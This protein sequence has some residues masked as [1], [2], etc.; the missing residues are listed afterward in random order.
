MQKIDIYKAAGVL[1][2]DRKFL[3]TRSTGKDFFISPG[4]KVE[5]GEDTKSA[6]VRELKEE[7]GITVEKE[8]LRDFGTFYAEAAGATGQFIQMNVLIVP[9]WTGEITP[10]NEVEEIMWIDSSLSLTI[11]L[12]SIF[13]HDV[14]PK[15]KSLDLID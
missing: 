15:L 12:G 8:V 13:K 6:L 7:L 11:K 1:L 4:G 2:Q 9:S 5:P 14:L 3:V 10:M